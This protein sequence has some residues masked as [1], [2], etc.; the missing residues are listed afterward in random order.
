MSNISE[1]PQGLFPLIATQL[2]AQGYSIIERALPGELTRALYQRV[3]TLAAGRLIRAGI[4]R[5]RD[6]HLD[7]EYRT[8][9]I[10]WLDSSD[11]VESD[12]LAWMEQL[13]EGI[14]RQ[15]FMGLFDYESHFAHYAPGAFYKRHLDAFKGEASRV[16][17]TVF[18]LNPEWDE[19]DGGEIALYAEE[20]SEQPFKYVHPHAGTLVAFL[21]DQFPHEV[22]RV[23]CNRYSIAGWFRIKS[24]STMAGP[25][26]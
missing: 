1:T 7:D 8:D 14:N 18:Y 16:V 17:T 15:L 2:A 12:Y 23:R 4:G 9:K 3:T 25:P 21:S 24:L 13:R 11:S 6:H 22:M 5:H 19:A 10:L 20:A 26:H